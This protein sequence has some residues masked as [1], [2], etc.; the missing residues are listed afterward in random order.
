M[1]TPVALTTFDELH[2]LI[3]R[4][5]AVSDWFTVSQQGIDRFAEATGDDQWLHV[6]VER[7][8]RESPYG[9][10]V[11]HGFF[12]L[13]LIGTL[14]KGAV[15]LEGVAMSVNYGLNRV[16]FM[17]PVMAGSRIRARFVVASVEVSGDSVKVVWSV[18]VER[19]S[20]ARLCCAAECIV[21]YYRGGAH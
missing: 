11:A 18:M 7:A 8:A 15:A 19:E 17:A 20:G 4:E 16:R 5:L 14:L 1:T 3:G 21:L 6:D 9:A 10:T 12:I 2:E 13:S